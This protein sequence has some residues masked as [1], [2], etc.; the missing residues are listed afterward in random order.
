MQQEEPR[1]WSHC[2][3]SI[4]QI[5][6]AFCKFISQFTPSSHVLSQRISERSFFFHSDN[7]FSS[8]LKNNQPCSGAQDSWIAIDTFWWSTI[9]ET[10]TRKSAYVERETNFWVS[11][12]NINFHNY[13]FKF[14]FDQN[15]QNSRNGRVKLLHFTMCTAMCTMK[16]SYMEIS[17]RKSEASKKWNI[18]LLNHWCQWYLLLLFFFFYFPKPFKISFIHNKNVHI[19]QYSARPQGFRETGGQ[20]IFKPI[21]NLSGNCSL[22]VSWAAQRRASHYWRPQEG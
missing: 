9:L 11:I 10:L 4:T 16:T 3:S 20:T 13:V 17:N 19:I 12:H 22:H 21:W 2:A 18:L 14:I 7:S 5:S 15:C 6:F 1:K 8:I